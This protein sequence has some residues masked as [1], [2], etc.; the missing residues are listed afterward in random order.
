MIILSVFLQFHIRCN[1]IIHTDCNSIILACRSIENVK[2]VEQYN[3]SYFCLWWWPTNKCEMTNESMLS[4]L[5]LFYW[6]LIN[7]QMLNE[8]LVTE[9]VNSPR[10]KQQMAYLPLVHHIFIE[11]FWQISCYSC[12][13]WWS[14]NRGSQSLEICIWY[15]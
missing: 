13:W 1:L 6:N 5:L 12:L 15:N 9:H 7:W 14:T 8:G 2:I 10:T 11:T 3:Q 4:F